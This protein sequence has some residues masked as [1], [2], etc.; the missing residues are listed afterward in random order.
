MHS[1][2][3]S[4]RT[5][6]LVAP[7]CALSTAFAQSTWTQAEWT[8]PETGA[9]LPAITTPIEFGPDGLAAF[10]CE[11]EGAGGLTFLLESDAFA[12]APAGELTMN[13]R[14]DTG[15]QIADFATWTRSD[16]RTVV[17]FAGTEGELATLVD[18]LTGTISPAFF[19]VIGPMPTSE[20]AMETAQEENR[21]AV[22]VL[23]SQ[24]FAEALAGL[25]CG[26]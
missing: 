15:P 22:V 20:E 18:Q 4:F 2:A 7:L 23:E 12:A 26:P 17:R 13:Y 24:G 25:P 11:V 8:D 6:V 1:I 14:M 16:D 19:W 10:A 3:R 9:A 5:F 21:V